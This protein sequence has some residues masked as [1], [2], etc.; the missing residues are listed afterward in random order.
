MNKDIETREKK[1]LAVNMTDF[2]TREDGDG[3]RH[4]EGYFAVFNSNYD[5]GEG[6]SESIAPGAFSRTLNDPASDVRALI[7][8]DTTLVLGRTTAG[9]LSLTEDSHGLRGDIL[10]NPNDQDALN[11]LA[12]VERGDVNQC[13]FGFYVRE[14]ETEFDPQTGA[15]HWTLKDV[16]LFEVSICTFPAY[17]ATEV[18]ARAAEAE[19]LREDME[20]R[21][22]EAWREEMRQ[23]L[24][25]NKE[26][27]PNE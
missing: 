20:E 22:A 21:K 13:S 7:N 3:T 5:I 11:A 15:V 8:H 9:T 1:L 17:Q 6:M 24:H 14:E 26:E 12:R 4:I 2:K 10:V 18:H 25:H 23:R 27:E 16:D 19:K